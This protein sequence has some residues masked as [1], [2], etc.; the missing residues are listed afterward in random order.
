MSLTVSQIYSVRFGNKLPIPRLVQDNI[1]KLRITPVAYKP[2]RPPPKNVAFKQ[3]NETGSSE[4]WRIK[5]ISTYVSKIRD[6]ADPDYSDVFAIFN[7]LSASNLDKLVS[8]ALVFIHKRDEEFRLRVSTLLFNKAIT[9]SMFASVMA[10]CASKFVN[11][12]PEIRDDLTIQVSM[13]PKLYDMN[14]TITYPSSEDPKFNDKVIEWMSQKNKRRGYAKF[15]TQLYVRNLVTEVTMS[16]SLQL[17]IDELKLTA[18]QPNTRETEENTTHFVDF[19][20]ESAKTL[21]ADA[22]GLKTLIAEHTKAVLS[23]AR[24]ELPSLCMRSRF[25]LEDTQKCVQ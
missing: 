22:I 24:S 21:P 25:K 12:I 18:T 17:V 2:F 6:K 10:D 14:S 8:D 5:S 23:Q 4:N 9:E 19:L 11:E 20:F 15:I 3:R 7:K 13:F 16:Q 1:A